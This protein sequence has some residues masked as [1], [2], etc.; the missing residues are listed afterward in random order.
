VGLLGRLMRLGQSP[1]LT[2]AA[3]LR[4]RSAT[5][6][7]G[8]WLTLAIGGA[9]LLY[10]GQT[11]AA[12]N[13]PVIVGLI[14]AAMVFSVL[15][16][17]LLPVA[18][19]VAGRWRETFFMGWSC[20]MIVVLLTLG[21]LDPL[22]RSPLTLPLFM[23]L[24]FAG[25]SYPVRTASIASLAVVGGYL[26]LVIVDREPMA[27]SAFVFSSLVWTAAM[28]LWQAQLRETQRSELEHHREELAMLSRMDSLTGALNRRGFD[29][30]LQTELARGEPLTLALLD[31]DDFKA[32]NDREGHAAGDAVLVRLVELAREALRPQDAIG[33]LGGDE[34]AIVLPRTAGADAAEP[35]A[36][37]HG[38]LEG[39]IRA[40]VGH[41]SFPEHGTDAAGLYRHADARL[42]EVKRSRR[43]QRALDLRWAATLGDAPPASLSW[44]RRDS[45]V[46]RAHD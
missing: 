44:P 34:F 39:R 11:W 8:A 1:P 22:E 7:A 24:L 13:R 14:A 10:V 5:V 28:C 27:Y 25:M 12:G 23:P 19:I 26:G 3:D 6:K 35:L 37:L 36:R 21:A 33:R 15:V 42:Y 46:G 4:F 40:S 17:T 30:R 41:S 38:A 31:L 16:L 32:T 18:P 2:D 29:E 45:S 20:A 9:G 43:D